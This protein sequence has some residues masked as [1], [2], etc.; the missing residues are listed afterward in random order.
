MVDPFR[1]YDIYAPS[2]TA[3]QAEFEEKLERAKRARMR[4]EEERDRRE[5]QFKEEREK[6][7]PLMLRYQK[8]LERGQK[9]AESGEKAW[10][11]RVAGRTLGRRHDSQ[12]LLDVLEEIE[13]IYE[14]LDLIENGTERAEAVANL[15]E[16]IEDDLEHA[17]A[18]QRR[19]FQ[20]QPYRWEYLSD[21][22]LGVF[23]MG[24]RDRGHDLAY[25]SPGPVDHP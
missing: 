9:Q 16:A 17:S 14:D 24:G 23:F 4:R 12:T 7:S 6:P 3:L 22:R 8:G 20:D 5:K 19:W 21:G 10:S 13:D 1:W 25:I 11:P 2:E 15:I 18:D